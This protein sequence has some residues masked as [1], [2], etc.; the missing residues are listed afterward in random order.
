MKKVALIGWVITLILILISFKVYADIKSDDSDSAKIKE[1]LS[2]NNIEEM[3]EICNNKPYFK[4]V[5]QL[6][7]ATTKIK[8]NNGNKEDCEIIVPTYTAPYY[9]FYQKDK[10]FEQGVKYKEA[11]QSYADSIIDI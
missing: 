9:L 1:L 4:N 3:Q 11:C 8:E 6:K 7:E 2:Q 5:C 10:W